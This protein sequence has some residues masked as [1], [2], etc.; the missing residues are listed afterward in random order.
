[1]AQKT[2]SVWRRLWLALSNAKYQILSVGFVYVVSV[3][4]GIIMVHSQNEF[5]LHY[6][7]KIVAKAQANDRA[8]IAYREGRNLKA[9][10]IDFV[11]NLIIGAV[12]QTIIGLTIVSPY[13]FAAFR[14]GIGGIVSVDKEHKSRLGDKK[15]AFY[16]FITIFL[17]LIPYSLAGGIGVKLGLSYFKKYPEYKDDKR[18]FG[19]PMGAIRDVGL[20]YLLV[21]P[22]FFIASLWEFLSPWN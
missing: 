16:Y 14:G 22:L 9:A 7:D 15:S 13:G 21:I 11:E 6:R 5:A 19:Y 8:A 10:T 20:T 3:S 12:P 1:M 18:Y 17:Q 4:I 2:L